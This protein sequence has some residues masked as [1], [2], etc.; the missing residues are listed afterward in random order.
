MRVTSL[1]F[2]LPRLFDGE[3]SFRIEPAERVRFDFA[4]ASS[5]E[6]SW[7]P[8]PE[9]HVRQDPAGFEAMNRALKERT[10]KP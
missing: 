5:S 1:F 9:F 7:S 6:V 8:R 4:T 10:E 2:S 3:H